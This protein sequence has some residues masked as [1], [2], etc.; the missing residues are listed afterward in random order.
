MN[1]L[2]T[3]VRGKVGT[4]TAAALVTRGARGHRHRPHARRLRAARA[5]GAGLP[6]GRPDAARGTRSPWCGAWTR[7]STAAA[8]PDPTHNPPATVFQNNLMATFNAI[9]AAVRFGVSRFVNI[10]SE[11]VPGFFFPERPFLPDYA[12]V[13]EDHPIRPQD[14]YALSKYFGELLMDAAVRRS[15]IRCISIRPCW[16]QHEGNYERNLGPQVRDASVLCPNFWSYIDVYDLADALVL[17]VQ[18]S[19]PGHEVFYIASPDNVGNR[20]LAQMIRKYYGE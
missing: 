13:D 16:V 17:A 2:V 3:G 18:S 12:P 5:R 4:A 19:L 8:I 7:S 14:P 20:P 1:V 11:T 10:S 15:D 9:E 6:P